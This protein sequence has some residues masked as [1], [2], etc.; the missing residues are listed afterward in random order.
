MPTTKRASV[1]KAAAKK[2]PAKKAAAKKTAKKA[3]KKVVAKKKP[4]KKV[5]KKAAAKKSTKKTTTGR[6][7]V[8]ADQNNA[9]WAND[10]SVLTNLLELRDALKLMNEATFLHHVTKEKNDFADWVEAV[11]L[12]AECAAALR[13]SKK[14]NT[15]RTV[16][17]RHI[18]L[19]RI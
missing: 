5:A 19:Y 9:F 15:A 6:T 17:V 3:V 13:K 16:V 4:A 14:A 7:L 10:G 11:L 12:D 18:K 8:Y 2:S 1:K